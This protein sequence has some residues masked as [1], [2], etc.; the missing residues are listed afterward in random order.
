M[1]KILF[2]LSVGVIVFTYLGY[3]VLLAA[4]SWLRRRPIRKDACSP[5]I[6]VVLAVHNGERYLERKLAG[7]LELDY[8]SDR[9]EIVLVSDGS[10]DRTV[11]IAQKFSNPRLRL[12]EL[13][14][15]FPTIAAYRDALRGRLLADAGWVR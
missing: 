4:Y 9:V 3:P 2:W 14:T 15:G 11:E 6:S 1:A 10:T 12:V 13:K 7:L 5:S 8:P